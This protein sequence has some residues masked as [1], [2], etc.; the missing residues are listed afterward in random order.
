[1]QI[2]S[3]RLE[4][5]KSYNCV[6]IISIRLEYLKSCNCVQIISIRMKY[7]KSCDC[8]QINDYRKIKMQQNIGNMVKNFHKLIKYR[9]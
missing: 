6:Q 4:Y 8:V 9:H 5:L 3:I 7:L 2:I 1:M